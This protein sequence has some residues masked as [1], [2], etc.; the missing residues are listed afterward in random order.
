VRPRAADHEG[1]TIINRSLTPKNYLPYLLL[2]PALGV[3]G[4]VILYPL[5]TS[6][7]ISLT[8][9]HL[10]RYD[11]RVFVGLENYLRYLSRPAFWWSLQ[12]TA[13]YTF[14]TV[15]VSF[16]LGLGTA[17]M[18][19]VDFRGRDI[20]RGLIAMP[21]ATPWLV[22]TLVWYVMFNPQM[23]PVNEILKVTGVIETG[24]PWLY[25]RS[26]AMGAII[27]VTAW[28][29]FPAATLLILAGLQSISKELYDA[30]RVDGADRWQQFRFITM[31]SLRSVNLVVVILMVIWTF[32]LFTIAFTLT[33]GG[34]G[35]ATNVLSVFTYQEAFM[36]NR[37]GRASALATLSVLISLVLVGIY[38]ALLNREPKAST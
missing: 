20:A 10:L 33:A 15:I 35:D 25:Q 9:A 29:L 5:V 13:I 18:L 8:D 7:Y 31:P 24:I 30:A 32:K 3:I 12:V 1:A 6:L 38:F 27:L 16:A 23:G 36:S 4:G 26:T 22:V 14:G 2:L 17:L 28:R 37:I 19:N 11:R 21:W 34:P